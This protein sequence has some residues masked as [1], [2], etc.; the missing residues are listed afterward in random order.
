MRLNVFCV[1]DLLLR[2]V[3]QRVMQTFSAEHRAILRN[4]LSTRPYQSLSP[5]FSRVVNSDLAQS[6]NAASPPTKTKWRCGNWMESL[7]PHSDVSVSCLLH[8]PALRNKRCAADLWR[9]DGL[10]VILTLPAGAPQKRPQKPSTL[11]SD[12]IS[13]LSK[14]LARVVLNTKQPLLHT[15][16]A[17][18]AL[19]TAENTWIVSSTQIESKPTHHSFP[20]RLIPLSTTAVWTVSLNITRQRLRKESQRVSAACVCVLQLR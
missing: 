10:V 18:H 14:R 20:T 13:A 5:L 4:P 17:H 16:G 9:A 7:I 15:V 12:I 19:S 6:G 8:P 2:P 11:G 1:I 3:Y